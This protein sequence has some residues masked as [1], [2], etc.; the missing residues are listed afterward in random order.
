MKR[1]CVVPCCAVSLIIIR[2]AFSG[3]C[4]SD[5]VCFFFFLLCRCLKETLGHFDACPLC[6][7]KVTPPPPDFCLQ[8]ISP[9]GTMVASVSSH[10]FCQGCWSPAGSIT[11]AYFI[12]N[13]YQKVYHDNPCSAFDSTSW[14]AFL[15]YNDTGVKLL[16][17]LQYAFLHGLTFTM[18]TQTQNGIPTGCTE[19]GSIPHKTKPASTGDMANIGDAFPDAFYFDRC[20]QELDCWGVPSSAEECQQFIA[21]G[22]K[23]KGPLSGELEPT[24]VGFDELNACQTLVKSLQTHQH[25]W[26]FCEALPMLDENMNHPMDLNTIERKLNQNAYKS[27]DEFSEDVQLTFENAMATHGKENP[28]HFMAKQ[29]KKKFRKDLKDLLEEAVQKA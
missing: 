15:P 17:R 24:C 26:M 29:L 7:L 28:V 27:V 11:I 1:E 3:E 10:V 5:R 14:R 2:G 23:P 13:G 8:G 12:P 6:S 9:S 4:I 22:R 16:R 25:G 19:W 21:E 20:N 18:R